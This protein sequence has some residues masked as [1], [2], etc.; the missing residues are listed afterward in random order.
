MAAMSLS[1][2]KAALLPH[3]ARVTDGRQ[4]GTR[5]GRLFLGQCFRRALRYV[6]DHGDNLNAP[7]LVHGRAGGV[8][9]AWVEFAD[10]L[11]FDGVAQRF[12]HRGGYYAALRAKVREVYDPKT[13]A[14][15]SVLTGNYG[16]WTAEERAL[17]TAVVLTAAAAPAP[18]R[19]RPRK[20][21]E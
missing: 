12:Y 6:L 7:R 15:L 16:P 1:R 10:W 3:E 20:K 11:V 21:G 14:R 2:F 5:P 9:H 19:G 13:A 4:A 8:A 17:L 18:Q